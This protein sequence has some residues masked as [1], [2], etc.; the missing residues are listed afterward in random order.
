MKTKKI[1]AILT[2]ISTII[3]GVIM[4]LISTKDK[5]DEEAE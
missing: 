4:Y 3:I 5:T 1:Q 2:L